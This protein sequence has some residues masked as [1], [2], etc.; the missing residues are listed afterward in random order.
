MHRREHLSSSAEERWLRDHLFYEEVRACF[1]EALH[2]AKHMGMIGRYWQSQDV[3][4]G[5]WLP[6]AAGVRHRGV[7]EF[8]CWGKANPIWGTIPNVDAQ[9]AL[10]GLPDMPDKV[11]L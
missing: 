1:Q 8:R 7:L 11:L 5:E 10:E 2:W 6:Y 9:N 4:W 3:P